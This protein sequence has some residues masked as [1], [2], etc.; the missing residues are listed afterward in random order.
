MLTTLLR[1]SAAGLR[2]LLVMTVLLGLAYPFAI[3]GV[4]RIPGLRAEAE[5]S[6]VVVDGHVV[7]SELIGIDPVAANSQDMYFHTRPSASSGGVLGSGDPSVSGGSNLAG[8]SPD[9]LDTVRQRRALIAARDGVAP[10]DVPPDAVTAPASGV[11]FDISPAYA[12][13]QVARVARA[14]GLAVDQVRAL[15][16]EHTTGR[17]LG[18]VGEPAVNVPALNLAVHRA[19]AG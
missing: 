9:L 3:Y 8:D 11:D 12:Q 18:F 7:G 17:V 1:Q 14:S 4:S 19:H 5:G 10:A 2:V 13:L 16:A 15:V 6:L